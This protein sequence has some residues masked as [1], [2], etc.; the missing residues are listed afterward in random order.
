MSSKGSSAPQRR[1]LRK[2]R[3]GRLASVQAEGSPHIAPVWFRFEADQFLV[4][5]E[6]G[7]R[8]HNN[9]VPQSE[10]AA[11]RRR[12]AA[13]IPHRTRARTRRG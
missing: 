10:S 8:N 7:S 4:L 3:I 13:S 11:L 12:R 6:R 5:T 9:V 1:F 2:P